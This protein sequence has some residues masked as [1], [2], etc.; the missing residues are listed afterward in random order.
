[1]KATFP[2]TNPPFPIEW[3]AKPWDKVHDPKLVK[4]VFKW[5]EG[6]G[7]PVST[8]EMIDLNANSEVNMCLRGWLGEFPDPVT[9][10]SLFYGADVP[11]SPQEMSFP[12]ESRYKNNKFDKIY[13]EA[14]VTIDDTKRYEL[15]LVADQMIATDVPVI[16][17][18]Y[19]EN[20]QL[21]QSVVSGYQANSMNIQYLT[22]VKIDEV[23]KAS[24]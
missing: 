17:L 23:E 20:Y 2:A 6:R 8:K 3:L 5:N 15:C 14:L 22:Y 4:A 16:P 24:K 19:H 18:W 13:E 21:I 7:F 1:M 12:N 11:A 10:L 9:F